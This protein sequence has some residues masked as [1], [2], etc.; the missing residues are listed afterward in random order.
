M[1]LVASDVLPPPPSWRASLR[2]G[3]AG[4]VD[5]IVG[6]PA[7]SL[8][9]RLVGTSM[10]RPASL[11]PLP[12][13]G[14][15]ARD[16][17]NG[18]STEHPGYGCDPPRAVTILGQA[19]L[20]APR[21]QCKLF[22][23]LIERDCTARDLFDQREQAVCGK[24]SAIQAGGSTDDDALAAA[25]LSSACDL[26]AMMEW[27]QHQ[28]GFNR[29]GWGASELS[30][31][32]IT[33]PG[34]GDR[35]W[36]VPVWIANVAAERFRIDTKSNELL[37]ATDANPQGEALAKGVWCVTRGKGPLARASLMR[38]AIWPLLWKGMSVRDAMAYSEMYGVPL[39]QVLYDD[40]GQPGNAS[41]DPKAREIAEE[42][43]Q[44]M[45][46]SGGAVT[47]KS[48]EVKVHDAARA[49]G[50]GPHEA[51]VLLCNA[52]LSKLVN[53]S[54]LANDNAG[55][56]G[57]SYALGA[58]H[59]NVAW[60][61][62]VFDAAKLSASFRQ[63]FAAPFVHYNKLN[64]K[65]PILYKQIAQDMTPMVRLQCADVARN[66]LG[67]A[68][69]INQIRRDTGFV[70]P[71]NDKDAAPGAPASTPPT[72]PSPDIAPAKVAA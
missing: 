35:L 8:A 11:P 1:N 5:D 34:L 72:N 43:V 40:V 21:L 52:E 20:G 28:L 58:V 12:P 10:D 65:P 48:V 60:S 45:G 19:E 50:V 22:D 64:A 38:T 47:P 63:A 59:A 9:R 2:A 71:L 39:L 53:G 55:S 23:D 6:R 41:A 56:G 29:Y 27:E 62:T 31:D 67:I 68:I 44:R 30:W 42:I 46:S 33:L 3:L 36:C 14:S 49:A 17:R 37:L 51:W 18:Y 69:S 70:E 57:A 61:K 54:T 26:L 66:K 4:A 13:K 25:A 24:P 16:L 32:W 15:Q 7:R